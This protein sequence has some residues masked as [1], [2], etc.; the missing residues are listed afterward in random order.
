[1]SFPHKPTVTMSTSTSQKCN[2][3]KQ[4]VNI[5]H[6]QTDGGVRYPGVIDST[7][8]ASSEYERQYPKRT[9]PQINFTDV[10]VFPNKAPNCCRRYG[11]FLLKALNTAISKNVKSFRLCLAEKCQPL[12]AEARDQSDN[13]QAQKVT[14]C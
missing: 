12:E 8:T 6:S 13:I 3:R 2:S 9:T 1:M 4:Y 10:L 11:I 14:T 5:V 7:F